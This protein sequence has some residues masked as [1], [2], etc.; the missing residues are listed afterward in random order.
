MGRLLGIFAVASAL[1][2]AS[3]VAQA[4]TELAFTITGAGHTLIFDLPQNPTP[5]TFTL[6]QSFGFDD[7]S[8]TEDGSPVGF[9]VIFFV[10]TLGDG[11]LHIGFNS[12]YFGDQLYTGSEKT[13]TFKIGSFAITD[14]EFDYTLT[15]SAVPEPSTWGL[16]LLGFAGLGFAGYRRSVK[17]AAAV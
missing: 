1:A 10:P 6:D 3:G 2:L 15:I 4:A 5:D 8:G 12:P 13:P 9:D 11:N 17:A 7:V 16:M 14:D